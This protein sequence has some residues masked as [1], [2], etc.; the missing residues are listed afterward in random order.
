MLSSHPHIEALR[1]YTRNASTL[2]AA[3]ILALERH[4]ASCA[5]CT[6]IVREFQNFMEIRET[7]NTER[8]A[9]ESR[10]L[11]EKIRTGREPIAQPVLMYPRKRENR[12]ETVREKRPVLAA[13]GG[14]TTTQEFSAVATLFSADERVMLRILLDHVSNEYAIYV[15]TEKHDDAAFLLLESPLSD[16]PL[17]TDDSG[18]CRIPVQRELLIESDVFRLHTPRASFTLTAEQLTALASHESLHPSLTSHTVTMR[19]EK[20]EILLEAHHNQD[21]AAPFAYAGEILGDAGQAFPCEHGIA[22]LPPTLPTENTR[23]LLY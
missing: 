11:L 8:V 12:A 5:F 3:E 6:D 7:V 21:D 13:A 22:H 16:I 1:R 4:L 10:K 2:P 14:E 9:E 19:L 23:F 17:M 18:M 20:D 15:L